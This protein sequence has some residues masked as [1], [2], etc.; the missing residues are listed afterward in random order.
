MMSPSAFALGQ[1]G[2]GKSSLIKRMV[3]V[4]LD[5]GIIPMALPDARPDYVDLIRA[6]NGQVIEFAPG[7]AHITL[8]ICQPSR[9]RWRT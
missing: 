6:A 2:L 8:W 7:R 3:A 4:L 9:P 1:P 5:W